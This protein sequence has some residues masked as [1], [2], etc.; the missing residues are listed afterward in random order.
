MWLVAVI[1]ALALVAKHAVVW[2]AEAMHGLRV[3]VVK[4]AELVWK[5]Q[6]GSE[7]NL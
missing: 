5:C 6:R 3:V 7:W 2:E 4:I 1:L